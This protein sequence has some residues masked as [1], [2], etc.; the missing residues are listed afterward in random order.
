VLF[1]LNGRLTRIVTTSQGRGGTSAAPQGVPPENTKRIRREYEE[2]TSGIRRE[3]EGASQ[4]PGLCMACSWLE[5]RNYLPSNWFTF[6]LPAALTTLA[7][8]FALAV[9]SRHERMESNELNGLV[10]VEAGTHGFGHHVARGR[11]HGNQH[12]HRRL[13][14][15]RRAAQ[16]AHVFDAA[17]ADFDLNG[18]PAY[19]IKSDFA[20]LQLSQSNSMFRAVLLLPFITGMM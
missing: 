6:C 12:A 5:G 14:A 17:L 19:R 8:G 2:N 3:Y 13:L 16:V 11:L 9:P 1:S 4:V 18:D 15:L 20:R 7:T 10:L